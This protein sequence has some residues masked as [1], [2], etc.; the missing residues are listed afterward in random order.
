MASILT[1]LPL[2]DDCKKVN[3]L[4]RK[5]E[6]CKSIV[7]HWLDR[8]HLWQWWPSNWIKFSMTRHI[9]RKPK[10]MWK[11]YNNEC[12][13]PHTSI[14]PQLQGVQKQLHNL[15]VH[16]FQKKDC[17]MYSSEIFGKLLITKLRNS[18]ILAVYQRS[19]IL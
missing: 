15:K 19:K 9:N 2:C 18:D 14:T 8:P 4:T 5:W 7:L 6:V 13:S 17:E 12:L 1:F 10:S 16:N 11:F 3:N